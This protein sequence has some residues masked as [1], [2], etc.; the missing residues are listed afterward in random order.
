M[1]R[2]LN[3]LVWNT[4]QGRTLDTVTSATEKSTHYCVGYSAIFNAVNFLLS[5]ASQ[6][7]AYMRIHSVED[8]R[9]SLETLVVH[10][11]GDK[12]YKERSSSL[13]AGISS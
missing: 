13:L 12:L 3:V 9:H 5:R 10:C 2:P 6:N 4:S 1:T 11:T 7:T 8:S